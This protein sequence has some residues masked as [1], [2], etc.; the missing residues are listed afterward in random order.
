[1]TGSSGRI[2]REVATLDEL[3][4]MVRAS[5]EPLFLRWSRGPEADGTASVDHESGLEMS[6]LSATVLDAPDWWTRPAEDWVARQIHK[7]AQL[8]GEDRFGWVLTGREVGRGV[9]HEPLLT[10]IR[11]V[12]R[13]TDALVEEAAKAYERRFDPGRDSRGA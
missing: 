1:M 2:P 8:G 13:L 11:P 7:Y 4:A 5:S 9:D 10:E 12:A 3:V 6:G